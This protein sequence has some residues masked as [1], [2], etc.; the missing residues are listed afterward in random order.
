MVLLYL[1]YRKFES[2]NKVDELDL[3]EPLTKAEKA[4]LQE[5]DGKEVDEEI[6]VDPPKP[7]EAPPAA[8]PEMDGDAVEDDG[9]IPTISEAVQK[10]AEEPSVLDEEFDLESL[11]I[12]DSG[13][14][15]VLESVDDLD[16]WEDIIS[17]DDS[18]FDEKL[19]PDEFDL[20]DDDIDDMLDDSLMGEEL[21]EDEPKKP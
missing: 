7:A 9:D 12:R 2:R 5:L 3:D 18:A 17:D 10:A 8:E 13:T 15:E 14:D 20:S 1:A 4:V 16:D 11:G 19:A 21:P 6:Y